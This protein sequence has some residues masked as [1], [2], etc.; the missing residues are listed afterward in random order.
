MVRKLND[1]VR[2]RL[3]HAACEVFAEAGYRGATI[4]TIA[5][6]AEVSTG[7]VYRYFA[8]KDALFYTVL[9]D[10]FAAR[11]LRLVRRRVKDLA[12]SSALTAPDAE[13]KASADALLGFWVQN[14]LAVITL[15]DRAQGSRHEGFAAHFV[16][17][18]M[19]ETVATLEASRGGTQLDPVERLVLTQIFTNTVRTIVALLEAHTDE[20]ETRRAFAG[21]WSHQLAGLAGFTKWVES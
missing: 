10:E 20:D 8:D 7:N 2:V 13:A 5:A 21:F 17:L 19:R 6:R 9:P 1:D 4:A 16:E 12:A 18:L 14:R 15:L 3:E 11:F